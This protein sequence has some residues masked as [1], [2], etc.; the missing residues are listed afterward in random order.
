MFIFTTFSPLLK[1]K[2]MFSFSMTQRQTQLHK[3]KSSTLLPATSLS[4]SATKYNRSIG[5]LINVIRKDVI[6]P[7]LCDQLS[8]GLNYHSLPGQSSKP[9]VHWLSYCIGSMWPGGARDHSATLSWKSR[10]C[11]NTLS[12]ASASPHRECICHLLPIFIQQYSPTG[13]HFPFS[14]RESIT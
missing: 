12:R 1:C 6:K 10:G 9:T 3:R 7:V 2:K 5:Y 8:Q 11:P 4:F 14:A 13:L